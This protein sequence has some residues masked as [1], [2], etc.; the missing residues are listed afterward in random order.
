MF[1]KHGNTDECGAEAAEQ[2]PRPGS[3]SGITSDTLFILLHAVC[4][5]AA[6]KGGVKMQPKG[7]SVSPSITCCKVSK[8]KGFLN[9]TKWKLKARTTP[10]S[11]VS[12]DSI[13]RYIGINLGFPFLV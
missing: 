10:S 3:L 4:W 7:A 11:R 12:P 9:S 8:A 1:V 5:M 13:E 6:D 2:G